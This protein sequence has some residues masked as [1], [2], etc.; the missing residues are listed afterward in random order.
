[1]VLKHATYYE[2]R[3]PFICTNITVNVQGVIPRL[4]NLIVYVL[5]HITLVQVITDVVLI[6]S[7]LGAL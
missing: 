2:R 3:V 6:C 4:G 7:T 5:H 1:M